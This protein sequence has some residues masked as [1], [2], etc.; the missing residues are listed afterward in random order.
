VELMRAE[1]ERKGEENKGM[2]KVTTL[3]IRIKCAVKCKCEGL[4]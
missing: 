4:K 1:C 2:K 3:G